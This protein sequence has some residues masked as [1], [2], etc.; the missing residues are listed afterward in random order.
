MR[1]IHPIKKSS[2]GLESS[3]TLKN[4]RFEPKSNQV[5]TWYLIS[6]IVVIFAVK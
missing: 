2:P 3:T 4:N 1:S 5:F 6:S